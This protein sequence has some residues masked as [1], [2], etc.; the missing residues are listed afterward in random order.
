MF[1]ENINQFERVGKCFFNLLNI[2][3]I[4]IPADVE[5]VDSPIGL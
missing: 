5:G 3:E 2:I 1:F 4:L